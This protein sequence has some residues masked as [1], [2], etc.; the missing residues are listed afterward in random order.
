MIIRLL[1]YIYGIVLTAFLILNTLIFSIPLFI[2]LLL[3]II[4]TYRPIQNKI[5]QSLDRIA[6]VWIKYNNL[7]SAILVPTKINVTGNLPYDHNGCYIMVCNHQSWLDIP[8][9]ER[10]FAHRLPLTKFLI[11]DKMK[12]LPL[13]GQ[14]CWAMDFPFMKRYSKSY[15]EKHPEIKE[16]DLEATRKACHKLKHVPLTLVNFLEGARFTQQKHIA[17]NKP[18]KH[19]L[20]PRAGGLALAL[21]ALQD[22]VDGIID[23]TIYISDQNMSIWHYLCGRIKHIDVHVN[24]IEVTNDLFGDYNDEH[25]KQHI[26]NFVNHLWYEK[27]Q[28]IESHLNQD[29]KS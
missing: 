24:K 25:H 3:K 17:Q 5:R 14:A 13:I 28:F 29:N 9:L 4:I 21:N 23:V 26:I 6:K 8:I 27:D 11:K 20:K 18:F 1:N 7:M 2:L 12:W 10:V 16:K 15:I 19:L 22:K